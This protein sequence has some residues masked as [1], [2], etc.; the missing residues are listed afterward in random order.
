VDDTK[1]PIASTDCYQD[2]ETDTPSIQ[3]PQTPWSGKGLADV[4]VQT[5]LDGLVLLNRNL[6]VL[7][8]NPSFSA[9]IDDDGNG[10]IGS[11]LFEIGEGLHEP[12]YF[13]M[14]SDALKR[15]DQWDGELWC[16][17]TNGSV[18]PAWVSLRHL[19]DQTNSSGATFVAIFR[20][21]TREKQDSDVASFVDS[22]DE[23]TGLPNRK[24]LRELLY[25]AIANA[26]LRNTG[27]AV[28]MIDFD[29]FRHINDQFGRG[30]AD[31]I[32]VDR[33]MRLK[34]ELRDGDA[35]GRVAGDQFMILLS[36]HQSEQEIDRFIRRILDAVAEPF[37]P[38]GRTEQVA[39]TA[40]AGIALYPRDGATAKGIENAA[41]AAYRRA[42]QQG[43]G[44]Y[45]FY[46]REGIAGEPEIATLESRL[47][48]ALENNDFV[49]HFQPKV[50]LKT[51][52][53]VGAEALVRWADPDDGLIEPS[54]FI[55]V[56]EETGLIGPLGLWTLQA[57]CT[58]AARL[59]SLGLEIGRVAVNVSARQVSD[60]AIVENVLTCLENAGLPPT[61]L[62][63]EITE[64]ALLERADDAAK[65]LRALH[66]HGV[67]IT[68][69]DFGTG[70]A[71][72]SYL[73]TFPIDAI[74][75]D[76]TFVAE[77]GGTGEGAMLAVGVT[78]LAQG[79]NKRVIAE[80]VETPQQFAV[81][82]QQLCD[83][84][85]GDYFSP[86]LPADEFEALLRS[87]HAP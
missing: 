42:K 43:R 84:M 83:E 45:Q 13:A 79:L 33:T 40:C 6:E 55:P 3:T 77:I 76:R 36:R 35:L 38:E 1:G 16:R 25:G 82:R 56:A 28:V 50:S 18:F 66:D 29:D 70:Y 17:R 32:L 47:R 54:D 49:L 63:L 10:T 27:C 7:N 53:I 86:P 58:E 73:L 15:F 64:S 20:D 48:R 68:A 21:I 62:E 37:T 30:L 12:N 52:R 31:R 74:K 22:K 85:Q 8:V 9:L 24:A 59:K 75:I 65:Q 80:G 81:L 69:D 23:L 57:A 26:T 78:A 46:S 14:I 4:L 11:S 39:M 2:M 72:L 5:T 71:S 67:Q 51:G 19:P 34:A 87:N 44:C 60:P 41:E 61:S